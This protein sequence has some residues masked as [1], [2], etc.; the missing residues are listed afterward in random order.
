M[1]TA[2]AI[3]L[4]VLIGVAFIGLLLVW[5][6][7]GNLDHLPHNDHEDSDRQL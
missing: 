6:N 5:W 3:I 1:S 7:W 4:A 2:S